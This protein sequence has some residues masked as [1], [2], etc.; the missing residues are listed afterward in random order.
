M[1]KQRVINFFAGPGA[2]KSTLGAGLFAE[3]KFRG[4]TPELAY[5]WIKDAEYEGRNTPGGV[6]QRSQEYIFAKQHFRLARLA[7][8]V[9]YVITDSPVILG[10]AYSD[11]DYLP[12][13]EATILQAHNRY[14]NLNLFVRRT[15]DYVQIGRSQTREQSVEKDE[16]IKAILDKYRVPYIEVDYHPITVSEYIP[17]IMED[18]GWPMKKNP[19]GKFSFL[20]SGIPEYPFVPDTIA[21]GMIEFVQSVV[22]SRYSPQPRGNG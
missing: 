4:M 16:Q 11:P 5:E 8:K 22:D 15:K 17:Q 9:D 19:Y 6:L 7:G 14:E 13:L 20:Q 18:I 10:V 1:N 3:L 21:S 12:A 2:G